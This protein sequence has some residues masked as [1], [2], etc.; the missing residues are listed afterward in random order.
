MC[1]KKWHLERDISCGVHLLNGLI[2]TDVP[3]DDAIVVWAGKLR[4]LWDYLSEL[5]SYVCERRLEKDSSEACSIA[6]Q[7]YAVF[8][9]GMVPSWCGQD[10]LRKLWDSLIELRSSLCVKDDL[11]RTVLR[12]ALLHC[13]NCA[14]YSVF[15]SGM[16]P[17]WCGQDKLRKLW[18]SLIELRSSLCVKDDVE[19]TVLRPALLH[20]QNCAVYSVFSVRYD[21]IVVWAG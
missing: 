16:M 15:P 21:A 19:R 8:P 10:K 1:S 17:S 14:V 11:E 9:S 18:D 4:E 13:Q 20:C 2:E 6:C 3:W 7:N 5:R 12:P